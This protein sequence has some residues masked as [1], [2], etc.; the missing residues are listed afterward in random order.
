[1]PSDHMIS[2]SSKF[3][4]DIKVIE[5]S[6][7]QDQWIT[8]GVKPTKPSEA[9]GYIQV[10]KND[11]NNIKKV[12]SFIEKPPKKFASK[13]VKNDNYYWNARYFYC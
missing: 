7:N 6:L 9:Y 5:N 2:N 12:L 13:F 3:L 1:M 8:L 10:V 4:N 11:R